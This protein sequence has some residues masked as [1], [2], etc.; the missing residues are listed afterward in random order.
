MA[1]AA[2]EVAPAPVAIVA[3]PFPAQGHLNQMLHLSLLLAS[4]GLDVHYAAPAAHV[5]QARARVQGWDARA[6]GSLHF[7]TLDIPRYA[8]PPPDPDS[9]VA[10]PCHLQPLFHAFCD[11]AAGPLGRLLEELAASHRR[12]VV[13]HDNVVAFPAVEA[14]RLPNGVAYALQ[15]VGQSFGAGFKDPSHRLVRALGLPVPSPESFLTEEFM[16]LVE[17]QGG[18]GVPGAGLLLNSC[19]ALEGEFIHA[20]AETLSLDGKR[21]FSIGP[22]N[23]LLEQD[24]DATK[25]ALSV[26]PRHECM[27]W[28]DK[29]PPSSVL[30]LCFGTMSSLPGK[31]I[32]ELAGALQSCEQRFIWV[33]RDADRADIFAEAGE[34]RHAKL[35]SDFTK[36]TEGRGLVITGWA[37]QLEILAHGATAFFVSHCGWNSLL[38]GLSHGKPILAWPM[39]SDQPWNAGYVC[40]HLKAGI[41]M[42]PWEK[43]RETLPAKEIQEVINRAMDSDQGI[44][45]RSAA[46]ALAE[47]VRAAVANGGSSWADMEEFIGCITK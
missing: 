13:V 4:R 24:L 30:Y 22:L 31:Q 37:P 8:A 3:V 38:E 1:P 23:P 5:R 20:Q 45:V 16:G 15:C 29:Q 6:V 10:F 47:D 11:H 40:G 41:V 28:L 25:P 21:L 7:A 36:R 43:S 19:R 35:M 39:H 46:K 9:P 33:L 12:V 26:Q 17:R 42:R 14:S 34:S 44:A 27:D 18:L 32:E 2:M